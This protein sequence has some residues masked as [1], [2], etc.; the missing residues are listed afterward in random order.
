VEKESDEMNLLDVIS[1]R[2][3]KVPLESRTKKE[4]IAELVDLMVSVKKLPHRDA[5]YEALIEREEVG[6]TGIGHGVALPHAKCAEVKEICV[7]CG[8]SPEGID[9][10]ALDREPVHIFFMILAPRSAP[11]QHL[12][13]MSILTR[14]LSREAAREEIIK[15]GNADDV[16]SVLCDLNQNQTISKT[17]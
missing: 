16:Y 8:I 13:I 1:P 7:S 6:S 9:F 17:L 3:I 11:G 5:I 14:F 10:D 15:A 12:K 4:V 2:C